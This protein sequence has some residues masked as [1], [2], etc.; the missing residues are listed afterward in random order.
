M[1]QNAVQ[2]KS[3]MTEKIPELQETITMV[4]VL[5]SQVGQD[6]SLPYLHLLTHC[7]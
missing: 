5:Q 1:E 3:N 6:L 4:E 2:R 7:A